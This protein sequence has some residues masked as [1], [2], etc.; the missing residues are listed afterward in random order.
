[1]AHKAC[2]ARKNNKNILKGDAMLANTRC[3]VCGS[4][5]TE[6]IR[7]DQFDES[8]RYTIGCQT[9]KSKWTTE[10]R[11]YQTKIII[12]GDVPKPENPDLSQQ[13]QEFWLWAHKDAFIRDDEYPHI[14]CDEI[15]E[16]IDHFTQ[17]MQRA[18]EHQA[19]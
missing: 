18:I 11:P 13:L 8:D 15:L 6:T 17:Q 10:V 16:T 12:R 9:C 5:T 1:M 19:T 2:H 7:V 14:S 4:T 3:P